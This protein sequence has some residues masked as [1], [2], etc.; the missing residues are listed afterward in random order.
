MASVCSGSLALMD[1]GTPLE[2]SFI[3]FIFFSLI[4]CYLYHYTNRK[5]IKDCITLLQRV[6]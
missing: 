5:I 4:S 3:L 2:L 1:A 6:Y